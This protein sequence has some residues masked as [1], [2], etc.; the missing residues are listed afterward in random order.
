MLF[1]IVRLFSTFFKS[2]KHNYQTVAIFLSLIILVI[3]SFFL[4]FSNATLFIFFLLL[5]LYIVRLAAEK[6]RSVYDITISVFASRKG[7][8]NVDREMAEITRKEYEPQ[9]SKVTDVLP[10]IVLILLVIVS[11]FTLY[12]TE[13]Y[14]ESDMLLQQSV[15]K[16]QENKVQETYDLQNRAVTKFVERDYNHFVFS[17]TNFIIANAIASQAQGGAAITDLD[18]QN[19][20]EL[21]QRSINFAR[22][23]TIVAPLNVQNWENLSNIYRGIIG[24]AQNADQF[25]VV[26]MQ[27]AILLDPNNPVLRVNL[28]GIYYQLGLYDDAIRSFQEG[29][30]LKNDYSNAYYNL[31]HAFE[32]KGDAQSLQNALSSYVNVQSLVTD[33]NSEDYK[34]ITAEID[35]LRKKINPSEAAT[36]PT[37][38]SG[39][40]TEQEPLQIAEPEAQLPTSKNPVT[41]DA[42][43]ATSAATPT[44]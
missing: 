21:V 43:P 41:V 34:K 2:E 19:I 27:Q 8:F 7:F 44:P 4:P 37:A 9:T 3:L 39:E 33:R 28:G 31:G 6:N 13:A 22:N 18:R 1:L 17:Q 16:A 5:G 32:A 23:A 24:F 40:P 12:K 15:V 20:V 26:S 35:A 36:E 11:G 25:A 14:A 29:I 30:S 10:Y 42:P 38:Q